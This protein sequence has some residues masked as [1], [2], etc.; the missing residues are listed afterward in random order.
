MRGQIHAVDNTFHLYETWPSVPANAHMSADAVCDVG[1]TIYRLLLQLSLQSPGMQQALKRAN[2]AALRCYAARTGQIEIVHDGKLEKICFPI[3][4]VCRYLTAETRL[5]VVMNARRDEQGSKVA[6]FFRRAEDMY[7]EMCWQ[8]QLQ[9]MR[10]LFWLS[11]NLG[12]W[13]WMSVWLSLILNA[14]VVLFVPLPTT[15]I[16]VLGVRMAG[17]SVLQWVLFGAGAVQA[18]NAVLVLVSYLGN[19]GVL[20]M[21]KKQLFRDPLLLYYT[22][23]LACCLLGLLVSEFFYALLLLDIVVREETLQNVIRSV[24]RNGKS[25]LLTTVFALIVIYMFSIVG[26]LFLQDDFVIDT[27]RAEGE[28]SCDSMLACIVT[29]LDHGLRNGGGIGDVLRPKSQAEATYAFRVV[30]D[31]LFFFMVIIIVLNLIFGV[32]IDTFADLRAE[33]NANEEN[34]R[35]TCFICGLDRRAFDNK[36]VS[37]EEHITHDHNMWNYL[38]FLVHIRGSDPTEFNGPETYVQRLVSQRCLDWFPRLRTALLQQEATVDDQMELHMLRKELEATAATVNRV[39]ELVE[40]T[41]SDSH[42]QRR[43]SARMSMWS[44]MPIADGAEIPR[45]GSLANAAAEWSIESNS[46]PRRRQAVVAGH[47]RGLRRYSSAYDFY[48]RRDAVAGAAARASPTS[49]THID[50]RE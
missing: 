10:L 16:S 13:K 32:I 23:Y 18:L 31:L 41:R 3:P 1:H 28:R 9:S 40:E 15:A 12:T 7:H 19:R 17:R 49:A 2:S 36:A 46:E 47:S 50:E 27:D 11:R 45:P 34:R 25:I 37:F 8:S 24:T 48:A 35:N 42:H 44:D 33:K 26:Y 14:L 22:C 29:T 6:D 43:L 5:D 39:K 38:Y 4:S 21:R 30:Y 20:L